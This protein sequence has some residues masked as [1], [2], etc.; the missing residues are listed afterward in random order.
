MASPDIHVDCDCAKMIPRLGVP[1]QVYDSSSHSRATPIGRAGR[2][3][4]RNDGTTCPL[5]RLRPERRLLASHSPINCNLFNI[6]C[7]VDNSSTT[8][9]ASTSKDISGYHVYDVKIR[10]VDLIYRPG[11]CIRCALPVIFHA[12]SVMKIPTDVLGILS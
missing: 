11:N 7:G 5:C 10:P 8:Q 6:K 9:I 2:A 12:Y 3:P 1:T 4:D